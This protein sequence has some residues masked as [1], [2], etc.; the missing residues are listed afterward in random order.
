MQSCCHT[1][2]TRVEEAL[3]AIQDVCNAQ[4]DGRIVKALLDTR[5]YCSSFLKNQKYF[6]SVGYKLV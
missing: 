6:K 2:Y 3:R 5:K 1:A 4:L